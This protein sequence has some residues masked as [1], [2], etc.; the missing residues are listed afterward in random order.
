VLLTVCGGPSRVSAK[1]EGMWMADSANRVRLLPRMKQKC[2]CLHA[3]NRK[4]D[5]R[6][7][8]VFGDVRA[9]AEETVEHRA[10]HATLSLRYMKSALGFP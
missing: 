10:C 9:E 3:V 8:L 7:G 5:L 2:V 6:Y 1:P 4:S